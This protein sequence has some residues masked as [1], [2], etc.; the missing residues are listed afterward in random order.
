MNYASTLA[1]NQ[2]FN[3]AGRRGR[4]EEQGARAVVDYLLSRFDGRRRQRRLQRPARLRRGRR[5][6]ERIRTRSLQTKAPGVVHLLLGSAE[7]Q[8]V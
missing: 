4:L 1:A 3:L 5:V 8:F 2:K 6:V 7:Y